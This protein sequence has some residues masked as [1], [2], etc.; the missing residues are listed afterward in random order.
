MNPLIPELCCSNIK[1]SLAFYTK[2]LGFE[3]EYQRE[4]EGFAMLQR[5]G[6]RIMLDEIPQNRKGIKRIWRIKGKTETHLHS[7]VKGW[8]NYTRRK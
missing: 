6:A 4:E 1:I 7:W 8:E 2:V 5:Q 3:I